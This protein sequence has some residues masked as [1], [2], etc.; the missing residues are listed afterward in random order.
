MKPYTAAGSNIRKV[1]MIRGCQR[2]QRAALLTASTT[3]LVWPSS[4]MPPLLTAKWKTANR[5]YW[6]EV[7]CRHGDKRSLHTHTQTHT[8]SHFDFYDSYL[9]GVYEKAIEAEVDILHIISHS[10]SLR[11]PKRESSGH[12]ANLLRQIACIAAKTPSTNAGFF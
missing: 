12:Q 7:P 1:W 9:K 6:G 4:S 5:D 10:R 8:N 2:S 11:S 3:S